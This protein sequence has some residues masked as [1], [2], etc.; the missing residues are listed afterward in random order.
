MNFYNALRKY[1]LTEEQLIENSYPFSHRGIKGKAIMKNVSHSV[2][3]LTWLE[4]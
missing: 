2:I 1:I 3:L 4:E